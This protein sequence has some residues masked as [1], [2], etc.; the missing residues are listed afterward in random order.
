MWLLIHA[1][2]K[3]NTC[4]KKGPQLIVFFSFLDFFVMMHFLCILQNNSDSNHQ[5][6]PSAAFIIIRM[7]FLHF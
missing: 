7:E 5:A 4:L 2:I 1:G 3:V 6:N